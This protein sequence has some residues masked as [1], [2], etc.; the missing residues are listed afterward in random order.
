IVLLYRH[1][2]ELHLKALVAEGSNFLSSPTD[3]ISLGRTRSLRWLA[4]IVWQ[5]I[6]AV[7]WESEFKCE[8]ISSLADFSAV[9]NELESLDPVTLAV[10]SGGG[11]RT[12][13]AQHFQPVKIIH[14]AK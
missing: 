7:G 9:V 13:I 1:S 2:T 6:K 4:Q 5:I 8:G 12:S 11:D 14:F 10:Q 3:P